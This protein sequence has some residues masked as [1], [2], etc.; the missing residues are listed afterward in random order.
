VSQPAPPKE[1]APTD[2]EIRKI[3]RDDS[4]TAASGSAGNWVRR[5]SRQPSKSVLNLAGVKDLVEKLPSN[6][7]DM[8]VLK[9]KKYL[10]DPDIAPLAMDAALDAMEKNTN[11]QALYIQNF[12][13][14]ML[15]DQALHLLRI[16]QS[17]KCKIWCLN[18]GET[19]NISHKVWTTFAKGLRHTNVTH[20]YASEHT[21]TPELKDIIREN[22]RDNRSKHKLHIDPN[23]LEVIVQCT[24]CWW[25]PINAK[26]LQPYIRSS[27]FA[28]ILEDNAKLGLKGTTDGKNI[29][30]I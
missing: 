3:L 9:M 5:S 12:N 28:D 26:V 23:N 27:G 18:I 25:N 20:M 16:L 15:D 29:D 7:S 17:P 19:Y 21:I 6:D 4:A 8:V 22:I 11:C 10:N 2:A 14:A 30:A 24:H 13:K 1:V